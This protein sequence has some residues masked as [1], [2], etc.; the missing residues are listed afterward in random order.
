MVQSISH[1][2]VALGKSI[3]FNVNSRLEY[4]YKV[5]CQRLQFILLC[6]NITDERLKTNIKESIDEIFETLFPFSKGSLCSM[7]FHAAFDHVKA[8]RPDLKLDPLH[9]N[10]LTLA[11]DYFHVIHNVGKH[12][13]E[14]NSYISQIITGNQIMVKRWQDGLKASDVPVDPMELEEVEGKDDEFP[15]ENLDIKGRR[16]I[17]SS[18]KFIGPPGTSNTAAIGLRAGMTATI[19]NETPI[20]NFFPQG[21]NGD[22]DK[23]ALITKAMT[24]LTATLKKCFHLLG[25]RDPI[26][27]KYSQA[28]LIMMLDMYDTQYTAM[29]GASSVKPYD[30]IF[31]HTMQYFINEAILLEQSYHSTFNT[32]PSEAN[33]PRIIEKFRRGGNQF[34]TPTSID[35]QHEA[36]LSILRLNFWEHIEESVDPTF[37]TRKKE[38]DERASKNMNKRWSHS[39]LYEQDMEQK[40]F[41]A[42]IHRRLHPTS[43][44]DYSCGDDAVVMNLKAIV[45]KGLR[46]EEGRVTVAKFEIFHLL[47][48]GFLF[49]DD[50][51]DI[52][53]KRKLVTLISSLF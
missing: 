8:N 5:A 16:G 2:G 52:S 39:S 27:F 36:V 53:S 41:I 6:E 45:K 51:I 22:N 31:A 28:Y 14:H 50:T 38:S 33:H 24:Q 32:N 47:M 19:F 42:L 3:D 10:A 12:Q 18:F 11:V 15:D 40:S 35:L 43:G 25:E 46:K 34:T 1:T 49:P 4:D 21:F 48:K 37:D 20:E 44:N 17:S 7:V 26:A 30:I 13:L 9:M 23:G 29:Y